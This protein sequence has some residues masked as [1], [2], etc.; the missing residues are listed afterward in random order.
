MRIVAGYLLLVA[1]AL[2]PQQSSSDFH[3]L[4]GQSDLERFTIRPG[5]TLTVQYGPD[6]VVCQMIVARSQP[7][8]IK[9]MPFAPLLPENEANQIIDDLAPPNTR[10]AKIDNVGGWQTSQFSPLG[11]ITRM[12]KFREFRSIARNRLKPAC[13]PRP[14]ASSERSAR[15]STAAAVSL[16]LASW[17]NRPS[18]PAQFSRNFSMNRIVA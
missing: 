15:Q 8:L 7:L 18:R 9:P 12:L 1:A 13:P 10:G 11:R 4:Y 17:S 14:F 5:V 16:A 2:I 3:A 6:E